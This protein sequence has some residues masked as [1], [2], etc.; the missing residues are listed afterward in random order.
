MAPPPF[1]VV[2]ADQIAVV[3]D[4]LPAEP[5][6]HALEQR[7]D[8]PVAVVGHGRTIGAVE[9]NL[10]VLGADPQRT[11]RLAA[12]FE[13]GDQRVARFDNLTIDDVASHA[14]AHPNGRRTG[15]PG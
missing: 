7:A 8:A 5:R 10:L 12:R 15:E 2:E 14:G 9:R 13:P 4:P 11:G 3:L 6:A 1:G